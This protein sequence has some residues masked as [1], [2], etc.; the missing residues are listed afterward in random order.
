M[1]HVAE[2]TAEAVARQP[3]NRD[4]AHSIVAAADRLLLADLLEGRQVCREDIFD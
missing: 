2:E 3:D 1:T 4:V